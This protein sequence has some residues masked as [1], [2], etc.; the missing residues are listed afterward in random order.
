MEF[1]ADEIF[2]MAEQIELNGAMFYREAAENTDIASAQQMLLRLASMEDDHRETF[3]NLRVRFS[4]DEWKVVVSQLDDEVVLYLR[5]IAN[6]H[7]FSVKSNPVDDLTGDESMEEI[8]RIAIKLEEDS[9]VFYLGMKDMVPDGWGKET[10]DRII[11]EERGH[12]VIL[13]REL[14]KL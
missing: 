4:Q 9:I 6:G 11:K 2:E 1:N 5:A 7:I 13:S 14:A 12:I 8:L 10:L 3:A